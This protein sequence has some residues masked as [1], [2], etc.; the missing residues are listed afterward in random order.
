M[1]LHVAVLIS[2]TY[3]ECI[4]M[5][6]D[7]FTPTIHEEV[8]AYPPAPTPHNTTNKPRRPQG[9]EVVLQIAEATFARPDSPF[10]KA[11]HAP[12]PIPWMHN[13]HEGQELCVPSYYG[14]QNSESWYSAPS[15][16]SQNSSDDSKSAY[17]VP[18]TT[19]GNHNSD[20]RPRCETVPMSISGEDSFDRWGFGFE[21][22]PRLSNCSS[23]MF[24]YDMVSFTHV[25]T[26]TNTPQ[27]VTPTIVFTAPTEVSDDS[28][29]WNPLKR[30][31]APSALSVILEE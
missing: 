23:D 4:D 5:L 16:Y 27:P 14:R 6:G 9:T 13:G 31:S 22:P 19:L 25:A 2:G 11:T 1:L 30:G 7:E 18:G 20:D 10:M 8:V 15:V 24:E 17:E 26:L 21:S 29:F 3:T 12:T 28:F